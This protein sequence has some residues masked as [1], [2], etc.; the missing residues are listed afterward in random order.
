MIKA[1]VEINVKSWQ[2]KIVNPKKYFSKKLKKI[3]K[4]V[5]YFNV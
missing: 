5:K 3:S 4:V 1:N 2:K